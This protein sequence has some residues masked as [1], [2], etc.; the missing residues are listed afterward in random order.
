MKLKGFIATVAAAGCAL[1]VSVPAAATVAAVPTVPKGIVPSGTSWTSAQDGLV[2]AYKAFKTGA[3]PYLLRTADAGRTWTSLPAPPFTYPADN[4]QPG[5][6]WG[7]GVIV[8]TNGTRLVVTRDG[9]GRWS[10]L[11]LAGPAALSVLEVVITGGRTFVLASTQGTTQTLAVYSG[12]TGAAVLRPVPGLS[13]TAGTVYGDITATGGLQ[14][15]LG[16]NYKTEHYWYSR[17]GV[18][19]VSAPLPCPA[20]KQA[21]L[22]G[23]VAGQV[24]A[25]CVGSPSDV[26]LGA[27]DKRVWIAARLGGT[28]HPSAPTFDS[29]NQ[30]LFAAAS[31]S[32]Q[33][34]ADGFTL[35][36]TLNA[37]KTWKPE[38]IENNGA[39]W[40]D[41]AFQN[42]T[43]GIASGTT[44]NN[45]LKI[46]GHVYRTTNAGRTWHALSLP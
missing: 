38:V 28:F 22:G 32:D 14:V 41:L 20:A 6:T 17:N 27:N 42:A 40:S 23:Q 24:I 25:L 4:D 11:R 16:A 45:S 1:G 26:G 7:D 46:V 8:A 30:Q 9:G 33:T 34:I 35:D 5:V 10:A 12:S 21:L 37:G 31:P 39:F 19:F 18:K 15:D 43:T 44:V 36:V 13:V 29:P 3:P 2:L